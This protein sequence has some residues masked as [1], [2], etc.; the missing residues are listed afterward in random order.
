M[1]VAT[2]VCS[3]FVVHKQS[4]F[5][6]FR[7]S[8]QLGEKPPTI[9]LRGLD[10][11]AT[12]RVKCIDNALVEKQPILSGAYLMNHGLD[13]ILTGDYSSTSVLLTAVQ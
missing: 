3:I 6:V 10:A 7:H 1:I 12:Y 2:F 13:F 8:Q 11:N 4:V 5:F 9:Y